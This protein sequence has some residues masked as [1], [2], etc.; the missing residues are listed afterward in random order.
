[1]A[2][3][4]SISYC[5][6]LAELLPRPLDRIFATGRPSLSQRVTPYSEI[7]GRCLFRQSRPPSQTW[8]TFLKNHPLE[9]WA[10]DF[11]T[12]PTISFRTFY[13]FSLIEHGR[14]KL[15]A[16]QR[17]RPFGRDFAL[18]APRAFW[19]RVMVIAIESPGR[20]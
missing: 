14:R 10:V 3:F 18:D 11:L 6:G 12:V 19:W 8:Q 20:A 7:L 13:A 9:L 17:D 2:P 15:V 1:M 4:F 16:R 5:H